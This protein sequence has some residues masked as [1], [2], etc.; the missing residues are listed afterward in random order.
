MKKYV[1]EYNGKFYRD[2]FDLM[3]DLPDDKKPTLDEDEAWNWEKWFVTNFL[4][5]DVKEHELR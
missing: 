1:I 2:Y 3:Q 4:K 5:L